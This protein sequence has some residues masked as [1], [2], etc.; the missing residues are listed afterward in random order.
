MNRLKGFQPSEFPLGHSLFWM[1]D[2]RPITTWPYLARGWAGGTYNLMLKKL[3]EYKDQTNRP[4]WAAAF[5]IYHMSDPHCVC[6][7]FLGCPTAAEVVA[8]GGGKL[9][10]AE[11]GRW[12]SLLAI[13]KVPGVNLIPTLLCGDDRATLTNRAFVSYFVPLAVEYLAP[14]SKMICIC[15]EP[16]KNADVQWQEWVI[17]MAKMKLA[18]IGRSDIYV[19]THLQ[20]NQITTQRP[21]NA[22]GVL[23][24]FKT[25]PDG[26]HNR[27]VDEVVAEGRDALAACPIP[28]GFFELASYCETPQAR[29]MSRRL[30][31]LPGAGMIPGPF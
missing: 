31:A 9:D 10:L 23:Y 15:S 20:G 7:P 5:L 21:A 14:Y 1:L 19:V 11:W 16:P 2:D 4:S 30:A 28:L 25:H 24:Q 22:D 13:G 3:Q 27:P 26:A 12:Q 18:A 29:E 8:T 6:N 17:D